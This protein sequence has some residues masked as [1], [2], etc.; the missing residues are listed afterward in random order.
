[1]SVKAVELVILQIMQVK[2][3]MENMII[4]MIQTQRV[5]PVDMS[6]R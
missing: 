6:E 2:T 1:M 5:I 3:D 4:P